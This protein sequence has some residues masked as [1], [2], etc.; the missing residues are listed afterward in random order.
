MAKDV[1][2]QPPLNATRL[3][4]KHRSQRE[5]MTKNLENIRLGYGTNRLLT[6]FHKYRAVLAELAAE[7]AAAQAASK[8]LPVAASS[9]QVSTGDPKS[10]LSQDLK[11]S[12][13]AVDIAR[14]GTSDSPIQI[15]DEEEVGTTEE[16][17]KHEERTEQV[18]AAQPVPD[19]RM[20]S[21]DTQKLEVELLNKKL[22]EK[23]LQHAAVLEEKNDK[24]QRAVAQIKIDLEQ[25][26]SNGKQF[27]ALSEKIQ[28]LKGKVNESDKKIERLLSENAALRRMKE[29]MKQL[30]SGTT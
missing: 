26:Q 6:G 22:K 10:E 25:L 24:I 13:T 9:T 1:G 8:G 7:E 17:V 3:R 21:S 11:G 4:D 2:P 20:S 27:V 19:S 5:A 29:K 15:I 12:E 23:D 16:V 18:L 14:P 28:R 30:V